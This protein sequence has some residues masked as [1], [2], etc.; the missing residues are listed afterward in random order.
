MKKKFGIALLL[1]AGLMAGGTL[2]SCSDD[3]SNEL[4]TVI[5]EN[6]LPKEAQTFIS[7]YY[8]NITISKAEKVVDGSISFYEVKFINGHEVTFNSKG[9]WIEVDAPDGQTIPSGIVPST[10]ENYLN[11]NYQGYGVN[12]INKLSTGY[13]VELV[14]GVDLQFDSLGN[15]VRVN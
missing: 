8:S 10:I 15:F 12:E 13:E 5:N 4:E 14:S 3:D 11:E 6:K 1:F 7:T 9:E 2:T